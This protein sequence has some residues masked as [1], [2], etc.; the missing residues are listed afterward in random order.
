MY[1]IVPSKVLLK[2]FVRPYSRPRSLANISPNTGKIIEAQAIS[3]AKKRKLRNAATVKW[4]ILE[5]VFSSVSF[6]ANLSDF[7]ITS[8]IPRFE[9]LMMSKRRKESATAPER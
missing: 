1:A 9:S 4:V 2:S 5:K 6:R 7:M 8:F 3:F